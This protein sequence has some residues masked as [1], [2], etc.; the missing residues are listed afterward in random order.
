MDLR[1]YGDDVI[2]D[3]SWCGKP[4]DN[5]AIDSFNG[6][7][8]EECLNVHWFASID[9]A[10]QKIDAFRREDLLLSADRM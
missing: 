8:R 5:T 3:F 1:A 2:L 7:F 6:R 10:Q 4:T 9:D